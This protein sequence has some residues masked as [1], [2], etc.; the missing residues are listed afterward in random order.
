MK[1]HEIRP[2]ELFDEYLR[3]SAADA[4]TYFSSAADKAPRSCPACGGKTHKPAFTK[5]GFDFVRCSDCDT[6]FVTPAPIAEKLS[7]FYRNS[8]SQQY[9]ADVFF[10]AVESAR[11][12]KIF[13]P[14]A[15]MIE[16]LLKTQGIEADLVVDVGA[17]AGIMLEELRGAGIGRRHAAIEP[18]AKLA[19]ACRCKGFNVFEGFVEDAV[20]QDGWVGKASLVTS[21]EVIEHVI[22]PVDFIRDLADLLRP[23]GVV[24]FTGLC[25]SGFDIML[26]N[27]Y[28]DSVSPPHHLNFIT[29]AG[30]SALLKSCG[31]E[32][33][34]FL[35]PGRLDVDIVRN[36]LQRDPN[37]IDDGF[38]RRLILQSDAKTLDAFQQFLADHKL[39]S[40]MW[41]VAR[42]PA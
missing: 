15:E 40:H 5:N 32:K 12:E 36:K 29:R 26:L 3:I 31:L 2:T 8:P 20:D 30:I 21:F 23:G 19:S 7:K 11:R 22:S 24:L 41:V 14:R 13:R 9:W 39:S 38:L 1:E 42:K 34:A 35:T 25:G 18:S 33:L 27:Q 16:R 17:G 4:S 28:S 10:P 6:L 37:I